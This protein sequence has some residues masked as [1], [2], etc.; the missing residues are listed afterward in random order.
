LSFLFPVSKFLSYQ[1]YVEGRD[2]EAVP[3]KLHGLKLL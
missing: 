1:T 3:L 2:R